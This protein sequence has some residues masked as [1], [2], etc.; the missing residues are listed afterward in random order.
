MH[1]HRS[2]PLI[3]E[4]VG[5]ARGNMLNCFGMFWVVNLDQY[6]NTVTCNPLEVSPSLH[7]DNY[8][9]GGV[10]QFFIFPFFHI[11]EIIIPTD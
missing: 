1:G 3:P 7:C 10:E 4:D 8:L 5:T 2:K 6:F 9:A 11:S